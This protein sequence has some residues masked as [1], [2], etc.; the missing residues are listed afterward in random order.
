MLIDWFTVGAQ[1]VN[2]AV[3][4]WLLRRFLYKPVLD[5]IDAREKRVADTLADA[6][7][8]MTAAK[9]SG[10][11]LQTKSKTFDD[12]RGALLAKAI[13]DA[14]VEAERLLG[15]ARRAADTLSSQRDAALKG[16]ARQ[17]S[18]KLSR[19][20]A[21]E[22]IDIARALLG[23]LAGADLESRMSEIFARRLRGMDLKTKEVLGGLLT[24]ATA[25]P[26]VASTFELSSAAR[27]VIQTALNESFA[28]DIHLTF[29]PSSR[30][31]CGIELSAGGQRL[32]WT[33]AD[34]LKTLDDKVT[35]LLSVDSASV[36]STALAA[37]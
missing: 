18:D 2:F 31:I 27:L 7:R 15:N 9:K 1:V 16:E 17:L 4:V 33:F 26:V 5:A 22:S 30:G 24:G 28:A 37:A 10:D 32:S 21:A 3:L 11:D 36:G 6:N 13:S 25:K 12:E 23:D 20:A 29:E 8:Q 14:N 35:G 34:Y 19:L